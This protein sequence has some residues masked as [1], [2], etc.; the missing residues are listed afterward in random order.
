MI[1]GWRVSH[2]LFADD[3]LIF[4]QLGEKMI[5]NLRCVLLHFQIVCGLNRKKSEMV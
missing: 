5:L 1:D 2:L 4:C 3:T